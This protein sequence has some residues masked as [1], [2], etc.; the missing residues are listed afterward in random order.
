MSAPRRQTPA[1]PA[2]PSLA[3]SL[4]FSFRKLTRAQLAKKRSLK[5]GAETESAAPS[6]P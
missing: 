6:P 4:E 5:T 1:R 3:G 2:Q